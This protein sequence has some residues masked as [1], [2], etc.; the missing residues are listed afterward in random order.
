MIRALKKKRERQ[1]VR[2]TWLQLLYACVHG[3]QQQLQASRQH[4]NP[5]LSQLDAH[6][7]N[8]VH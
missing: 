3:K 6:A 2:M 4:G 1:G 7:K 5:K 8:G